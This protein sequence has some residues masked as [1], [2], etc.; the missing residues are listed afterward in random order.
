MPTMTALQRAALKVGRGGVNGA[1]RRLGLGAGVGGALAFNSSAAAE[2][3]ASEDEPMAAYEARTANDYLDPIQTEGFRRDLGDRIRGARIVAIVNKDQALADAI[4]APA[5]NDIL[6]SERISAGQVRA[7]LAALDAADPEAATRLRAQLQGFVSPRDR[8][9]DEGG[10][11][12]LGGLGGALAGLVATRGKARSARSALMRALGVAGASALGA[13]AGAAAQNARQSVLTD[14][15][16][17]DLARAAAAAGAAGL[18]LAGGRSALRRAARLAAVRGARMDIARPAIDEGLP[19]LDRIAAEEAASRIAREAV[20]EPVSD[21]Q[22]LAETALHMDRVL[23]AA[24]KGRRLTSGQSPAALA[25]AM[26][27]APSRRLD[28]ALASLE[29][30]YRTALGDLDIGAGAVPDLRQFEP[31]VADPRALAEIE[32][33]VRAVMRG[34]AAAERRV[35]RLPL[36][37]VVADLATLE[38][39]RGG[40]DPVER[41]AKRLLET[42]YLT[43]KGREAGESAAAIRTE[44]TLKSRAKAATGADSVTREDPLIASARGQRAETFTKEARAR[45]EAAIKAKVARLST[46]IAV[47]RELQKATRAG[48]ARTLSDLDRALNEVRKRALMQ[49]LRVVQGRERA[50]SARTRPKV[51]RPT[52]RTDQVRDDRPRTLN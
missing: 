34:R 17:P 38:G 46:E 10:G 48:Q 33:R 49:R 32:D 43:L 8:D 37:G 23:E 31:D 27:A 6:H 39:K 22:L 40:L 2:D 5:V 42:R 12:A 26:R 35:A 15:D 16:A 4:N 1:M 20:R 7:A 45:G 41:H 19:F 44:A 24:G 36:E 29:Q 50:G 11:A 18:T 25:Q 52:Q 30:D 13:G 3:G 9:V 28:Q 51:R 21:R 47:L 14:R